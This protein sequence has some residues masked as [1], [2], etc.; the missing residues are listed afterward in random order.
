MRA[1][2]L[3]LIVMVSGCAE[4]PAPSTQQPSSAPARQSSGEVALAA[5][6]AVLGGLATG[7]ASGPRK[8]WVKENAINIATCLHGSAKSD[9]KYEILDEDMETMKARVYWSG[10]FGSE[11]YSD[12]LITFHNDTATLSVIHDS[13]NFSPNSDCRYLQGV[14]WR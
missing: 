2:T 9:G 4:S 11:H 14:A 1:M 6:G 8:A 5:A 13:G 10:L 12:V 3:M 7:M